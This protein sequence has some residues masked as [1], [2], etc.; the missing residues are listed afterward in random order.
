M[1]PGPALYISDLDGTLLADDATSR[2]PPRGLLRIL[3]A[4]VP[5][6]VASARSIVSIRHTLGDLPLTL[7][8]IEI[9]GAF[10]TDYATARH[11][12]VNDI[13]KE[14]IATVY[15]RIDRHGCVPIL[16][17]FDGARDRVYYSVLANPA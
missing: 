2:K 1:T 14:L 17:A 9:N 3:R 11:Q 6:T 5:F 15:S 10:I 8:V 7:P 13:G 16:S 4:G 12:A